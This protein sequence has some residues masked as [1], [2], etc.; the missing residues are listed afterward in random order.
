MKQL[1]AK[2]DK[3]NR[4]LSAT[5]KAVD[6]IRLNASGDT[7]SR[8]ASFSRGRQLGFEDT[9]SRLIDSDVSFSRFGDGELRMMTRP[10][11]NL[12]FQRNNPYIRR[13]LRK[14]FD[15]GPTSGLMIGWPH[16]YRDT[17]G[18]QLW[19]LIWDA[20]Q[21]HI[22]SGVQYGNSHVSRPIFFSYMGE[23]GITAWRE[24]WDQK[25]ICVIT[26][27]DSRF[28][29]VPELFDGIRDATM[30]KSVPKNADA[31][32]ER[33]LHEVEGIDA[34]IFFDFTRAGRNRSVG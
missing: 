25:R 23:S 4:E 5:R 10:N 15:L 27:K 24:V 9:M 28:D 21:P 32:I 2:V 6:V 18:T 3:L 1:G 14:V 16:I 30:L 19:S 8:V 31:D 11:S 20:L 33:L 26:G 13:E 29:L 7:L 22:P 34:D 17:N 12:G